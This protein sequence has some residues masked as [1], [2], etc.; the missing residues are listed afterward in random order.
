MHAIDKKQLKP[1]ICKV[2][3]EKDRWE[4]HWE[5]AMVLSN[6]FSACLESSRVC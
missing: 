1:T 4:I 6:A 2:N 3:L 5:N